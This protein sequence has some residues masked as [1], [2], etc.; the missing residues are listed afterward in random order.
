MAE[1]I[2]HAT[3]CRECKKPYHD[4]TSVSLLKKCI[5]EGKSEGRL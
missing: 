2:A 5:K 4:E 3:H 1:N